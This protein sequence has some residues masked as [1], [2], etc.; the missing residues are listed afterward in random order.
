MLTTGLESWIQKGKAEFKT[1]CFGGSGVGTIPIPKNKFIIITDFDYFYFSDFVDFPDTLSRTVF[2]VQFRSQ[3]S[4]N[5]FIIRNDVIPIGNPPDIALLAI[6]YFKKD[7]YMV[8][9]GNV[10][11]DIVNVPDT[12]TWVTTYS[13]LPSVSNEAPQPVGYGVLAAGQPATRRID[14]SATENYLPLTKLRDDIP[15]GNFY[16]EQFKVDVNAANKLNPV[17][18]DPTI[19]NYSYPIMNI[20]Y[21]EFNM[22]LN[23]FVQSS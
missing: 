12:E 20:S 1:F 7:T 10:Q 22:N 13:T 8:H 16:R 15:A 4:T 17:N 5:H 18:A 19:G 6:G 9:E 23:Q 3:K 11:L 14:F 21:V 2:Q